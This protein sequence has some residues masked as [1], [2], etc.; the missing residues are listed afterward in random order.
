MK[1]K[2]RIF[3]FIFLFT[4]LMFSCKKEKEG[5]KQPTETSVQ[6][7][8][9]NGYMDIYYNYDLVLDS[10]RLNRINIDAAFSDTLR[11]KDTIRYF[12]SPITIDVGTVKINEVELS[13][14]IFN[15]NKGYVYNYYQQDTPKVFVNPCKWNISGN[16][17]F[18]QFNFYDL[19]L[20]PSYNGIKNLPDTIFLS[21][22]NRINIT[23]YNNADK[24][25]ITIYSDLS[26]LP[27]QSKTKTIN[28]PLTVIDFNSQDLFDLNNYNT[29]T[30]KIEVKLFKDNFV[31][32][33]GKIFNFRTICSFKCGTI[34]FKI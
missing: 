27:A 7:E 30:V 33:N 21:K 13:K 15:F 20:Y 6:P 28:Y 24:L 26:S 14:G 9:I 3:P 34:V 10:F 18:Q 31:N 2:T 12:Y 25:E 8:K 17:G 11:Q 19:R 29:R 4:F 16:T 5:K 32:I 22:N 1:Y 23:N